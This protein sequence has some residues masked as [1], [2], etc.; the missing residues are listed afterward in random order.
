MV[1]SINMLWFDNQWKSDDLAMGIQYVLEQGWIE[2][3]TSPKAFRLTE[4]GF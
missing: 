4:A 1:G 2:E 3:V